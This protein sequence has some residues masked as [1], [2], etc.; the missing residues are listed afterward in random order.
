MTRHNRKTMPKI[1]LK[2]KSPEFADE[3]YKRPVDRHC[4]MPGCP[5]D[6]PHKAPK[7]RGLNDYYWFCFD[8]VQEYNKAWDF[9]SG[10]NQND[11]EDQIRKSFLWD[12]PTKRFDTGDMHE[13]L[14]RKA[15]QERN[16]SEDSP[17]GGQKGNGFRFSP[18][19]PMQ[20]TPEVQAMA[21]M[22]L[23]PPLD[24]KIIK[25]RYKELAKK[26]HPDLNPNDKRAEEMIKTVNMSYTILK[27][28]C[29]K[30]DSEYKD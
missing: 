25:S 2:H 12:R 26:Y 1:V 7:H 10:M 14:Y 20:A 13:K 15:W 5:A 22:G 16:F 17:P 23:E 4:D 8:H 9:F 28:A 29:E 11:I 18:D 6:A 19:A 24:I 21:I 3:D 27:L 30:Y